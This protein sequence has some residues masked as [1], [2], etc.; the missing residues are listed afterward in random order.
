MCQMI[1]MKRIMLQGLLHDFKYFRKC[2][3]K[4]YNFYKKTRFEK[5]QIYLFVYRKTLF[6]AFR[7]FQSLFGEARERSVKAI[8]FAKLLRKDL[9]VSAEFSITGSPSEFLIKLRE[10][11]HVQVRI[12]A[13]LTERILSCKSTNKSTNKCV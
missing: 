5:V 4:Y 9:E 7:G 10:T 12:Y 1:L 13:F 3:F 2:G 6:E 11:G 8:A